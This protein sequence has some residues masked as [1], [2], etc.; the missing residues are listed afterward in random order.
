VPPTSTARITLPDRYRIV[1]HI[2]NGGMAGV[3]EATDELLRRSVAVKVLAAHLSE[4]DRARL[5]FEREARAAAALS[6]HPNVVTIYDV[7]EHDGRVFMVMELM[8]GGTVADRLRAGRTIADE[9]ALR[10][11]REAAAALDAAHDQGVV[12]RDIKPGNLLLDDRDRLAIAD[13]GIARLALEDQLTA[14]G[15]VL[16]TASY[17][18]PEQAVGEPAT[19]ASDRYA[20]AVVAFELLT[21]S[22]PFKAEHFA[23]QARAHVEDEPPLATERDPSLPRGVD[24]VLD[25]GLAKDPGDRWPSAGAMVAALDRAMGE[26]RPATEPTRPITPA[27][28]VTTQRAGGGHW[29]WVLAGVAALVVLAVAGAVLLS[30]GDGGGQEPQS[31][32]PTTTAT[33]TATAERTPE[34][35]PERTPEPTPE[36]TAEPTPEATQE[37][38]AGGTDLDRAADLQLQGYNARVAGNYEQALALSTQALEACGDTQQLSPCGYAL[39]EVGAALNALGRPDEAIPYLQQRLDQYGPNKDVEK[40]LKAAEKAAKQG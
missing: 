13:F 26:S 25:R 34:P 1:R 5:R 3:W 15:Q 18:S 27:P 24:A 6:S 29:P 33:A 32:Q 12:H 10:W 7:G 4:D 19:A 2:A 36:K 9:T 28:P 21:G 20:L 37:P 8:P 14:T 35:T 16:G 31:A 30:D 38:P 11:L 23:A 22:R 17:I 39:Y 40:E